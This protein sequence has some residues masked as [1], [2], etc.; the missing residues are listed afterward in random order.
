MST[1]TKT[2]KRK[3]KKRS[4]ASMLANPPSHKVLHQAIATVGKRKAEDADRAYDAEAAQ[5]MGLVRE[6]HR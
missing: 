3:A 1:K 6:M 4:L 2:R 5:I